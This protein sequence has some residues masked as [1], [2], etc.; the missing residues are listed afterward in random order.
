MLIGSTIVFAESNITASTA[1]DTIESP[2][3]VNVDLAEDII[4]TAMEIDGLKGALIHIAQIDALNRPP[5][6]LSPAASSSSSCGPSC[7]LEVHRPLARP[8]VPVRARWG[9]GRLPLS[10][11]RSGV[12]GDARAAFQCPCQ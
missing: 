1:A 10:H 12:A 6:G 3:C 7:H 2:R 4:I 9:R 11:P 5:T 8:S